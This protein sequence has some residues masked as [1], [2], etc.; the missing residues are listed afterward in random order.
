LGSRYV[1]TSLYFDFIAPFWEEARLNPRKQLERTY[2]YVESVVDKSDKQKK[3]E[4]IERGVRKGHA[5]LIKM[6]KY[7]LLPPLS[8][9][10][11][12]SNKLG[13]KDVLK[14]TLPKFWKAELGGAGV[15]LKAI[16]GQLK[17]WLERVGKIVRKE[18]ANDELLGGI[19]I[20]TYDKYRI[21][22]LFINIDNASFKR[23]TREGNKKGSLHREAAQDEWLHCS[24]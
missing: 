24:A 2:K 20:S 14:I 22:G 9:N 23:Q 18:A 12:L 3:R 11:L 1:A 10:I 13:F 6:S 5:E 16:R 17:K 21:L 19:N 7:L 4:Q 8:F 15:T